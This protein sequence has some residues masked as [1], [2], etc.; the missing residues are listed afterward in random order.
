MKKELWLECQKRFGIKDI[1][2]LYSSS[3]A[4]FGLCKFVNV[5]KQNLLELLFCFE[6]QST[7]DMFQDRWEY[8]RT[9]IVTCTEDCSQCT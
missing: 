2:E 6:Q 3:E 5:K 4:N 7:I 1:A 9:T 8:Y